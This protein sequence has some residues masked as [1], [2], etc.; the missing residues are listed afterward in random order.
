MPPYRN[1]VPAAITQRAATTADQDVSM[2]E[3]SDGMVKRWGISREE[4]DEF[5]L[6]SQE[7]AFESASKGYFKDEIVPS[8]IKG[9]KKTPDKIFAEDEFLRPETTME[10][11][12]KLRTV[13]GGDGVTTSGNASGHNG[14]AGFLLMMTAEKAKELGYAPYARWVCGADYGVEPK[15]M[16]IGPVYSNLM[17]MKRAGLQK[18]DI[19]VY[20][21]NEAFAA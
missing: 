15:F 6:R 5:A 14:D 3:I 18:G 9:N 8:T 2:I 4:C 19:S 17:A 10:S 16:G 7:R 1:V 11:L 21:C 20:E 12:G 13:L